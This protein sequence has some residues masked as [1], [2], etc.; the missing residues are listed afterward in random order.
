MRP[1]SNCRRETA[2]PSNTGDILAAV[3]NVLHS[4]G[5]PLN[6]ETRA[7]MEPRFGHDFSQVRVHTDSQAAESARALGSRAYTVGPN[8][9]FA[10]GMYAP[11]N[12]GG[13]QLL[14]HELVH[15]VQQESSHLQ[16]ELRIGP[17]ADAYEQQAEGLATLVAHG[18][19]GA[20]P[21]ASHIITRIAKPASNTIQRSIL[22]SIMGAVGGALGG[23]V[24][25]ALL[26]GPIGALIGGG[27]G[28]IGGA[29]LGNAA[30]TPSRS[31]TSAEIS[32]AREIYQDSI[33]YSQITITRDSLFAAGAPRTIGNTIHLKSDWRHF[34]KDTMELT[35]EGLETLIHEMGH[36]W[37]YQNG[38]LEYIPASLLAQL[39]AAIS[40]KS[41]NAA[42]DWE[43][44]HA[45]KIP[46]ERWNPEQQAAAIE[47]YNRTLRRSKNGTATVHDFRILSVL[48]PYIEKVRKRE[49]APTWEQPEFGSIPF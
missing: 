35:Q 29:L 45:S 2:D 37:Q 48:L 41:R 13:R 4:P 21:I 6:P 7:F 27:V 17:P 1:H 33:D 26:G 10:E 34:K 20:E 19:Q 12:D 5:H 43:Q 16:G 42:Y 11:S 46:W 36:V 23:V 39:E 3:R 14:A 24:A 30:S 32:Y 28:L 9:V 40:G 22:G 31:L 44:A 15:V 49:G 38:G 18:Q 47:E 25:G 8:V